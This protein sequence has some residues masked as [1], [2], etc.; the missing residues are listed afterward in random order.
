MAGGTTSIQSA[1]WS[2]SARWR[3]G[4]SE[5]GLRGTPDARRRLATLARGDRMLD[6]APNPYRRAPAQTMRPSVAF[7]CFVLLAGCAW[8]PT[9]A[10][11]DFF[12][13]DAQTP[14]P[15]TDRMALSPSF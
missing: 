7:A 2:C 11:D 8:R 15:I 13:D 14:S 5:A 12:D 3:R 10:A 9:W 6:D 4:R 1:R